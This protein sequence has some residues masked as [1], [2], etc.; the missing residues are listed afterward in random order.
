[1]SHQH[2]DQPVVVVERSDSG[3]GGFL[4]GLAV[5]AGV[6]LLFAPKTGEETR[7]QLKNTGRRLRTVA[8]EKAEDLQDAMG[9]GY[10][11]TRDR[12]EEGLDSARETIGEKREAAQD[13]FE[14][15]KSAVKTARSEL[16]R[17]LA[18][19]KAARST[20][21]SDGDKKKADEDE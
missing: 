20:T 14:A 2:S 21:R 5:G 13:A 15:G 19:S 11:R 12:I 18:K 16:E 9:G 1:M 17:R 6:A 10:E 3:L 8:T 4:L 7:Q